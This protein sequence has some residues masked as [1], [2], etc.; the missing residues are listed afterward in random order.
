MLKK[1]IQKLLAKVLIAVFAF[2]L[3]TCPPF[4]K[5]AYV[6]A[7]GTTYYVSSSE[8]NDSNSGTS[9]TSP[10]RTLSKVSSI[11]FQSGDTIRLKGGD[12]WDNEF[13][14][15]HGSGTSGSPITLSSY[16]TG[17]PVIRYAGNVINLKNE[18]FWTI[19]G[20]EVMVLCDSSLIGQGNSN[21][22]IY[23]YY[24]QKRGKCTY[25]DI[26]IDDNVVY[27]EGIDRRT[28]GILVF[29]A[30]ERENVQWEMVRNIT[31]SNNTLYN[32]GSGGI[33]TGT[34][35]TEEGK[36]M[37][38]SAIF[39]NVRIIRN[40]IHDIG[41]SV[42]VLENANHSSM[43]WN[44]VYRGGAYTGSDSWGPG[45]IWPIL[46]SHIEM[47]FNEAYGMNDSNSGWDGTGLNI[48]WSNEYVT[49]QYNY[50]HDNEGCGITSMANLGSRILNN[51][52]KGN[53]GT[54][55]GRAQISLCDFTISDEL[56]RHSGIKNM[57]VADNMIIVDQPDACA[58]YTW[59]DVREFPWTGNSYH[60][61]RIV[62]K[63]GVPGTYS[64]NIMPYTEVDTINSNTIYGATSSTF[65]AVKYNVDRNLNEWKALGYDLDSE[66]VSTTDTGAPGNVSN[67]SAS[68]SQTEF[69]MNLSWAAATDSGS[70]IDHYNIYRWTDNN[71]SPAYKYMVGESKTTSFVDKEELEP[72]TT[73]YYKVEAEDK[74][75][76]V[77]LVSQTATATSGTAPA[78]P[79]RVYQ[80][81]ENF[82]MLQQ[83]YVWSYQY[84]D[85]SSYADLP[86]R[87]TLWNCWRYQDTSL[88]V[89]GYWLAPGLDKDAVMKWTAP[90]DGNITVSSSGTIS[91]GAGGDG[92]N[93]KVL[94]G[95]T[96]VWPSSGWQLVTNTSPVNFPSAQLSVTKGEALYFIVN[97][98]RTNI[99][100]TTSWD[101]VITYT[102]IIYPTPSA[103]PAVEPKL[104]SP[105]TI[106][107]VRDDFED[108]NANGWT[109]LGGSWSVVTDPA[110]GSKV[111]E[112]S[113]TQGWGNAY[114]G[115]SSW[116]D[117]TV[118]AKFKPIA[119][120]DSYSSVGVNVMHAD[121]SNRYT[122]EFRSNMILITKFSGGN[123]I[124][125]SDKDYTI[126]PGNTYS[127]KVE[128]STNSWS[129]GQDIGVY[130]NGIKELTAS[131]ST[132]V[133]SSGRV[134]LDTWYTRAQFDDVVI[135]TAA[136]T[137]VEPQDMVV[138]DD[139]E[140]GNITGWTVVSGNWSIGFDKSRKLSQTGN[141]TAVITAGE[142]T[143]DNY[144]VQSNIKILSAESGDAVAKLDLRYMDNNNKYSAYIS[145]TGGIGIKKV[146]S[147]VETQLANKPYTI[148][149]GTEYTVKAIVSGSTI[150]LYINGKRELMVSDTAL[151][152]GKAALETFN[153]N[154]M[155]DEAIVQ[156]L[157]PG[158]QILFS[159][160]FE[161]GNVSDWNLVGGAWSVVDDVT[162]AYK[163]SSIDGTAA[164]PN[165]WSS[166]WNDYIVKA[167]IKFKPN[168]TGYGFAHIDFRYN[169]TNGNRYFVYISDSGFID[170]FKDVNGVRTW[171]DGKAYYCRPDREYRLKVVVNGSNYDVYIN[172]KK[173]L[174]VTD[175]DPYLAHGR[176]AL[177]TWHT[178]AYY[179]DVVV[180]GI[181]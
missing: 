103:A 105:L 21:C 96:Q 19:K 66:L 181:Y 52:V 137:W 31:I 97:K 98:N 158:T 154:V 108:G 148:N 69:A 126:T 94:K 43:K 46:S 71:F 157:A 170:I 95:S 124:L 110:T 134:A 89:G 36:R 147:G 165:N 8:G 77:G 17:R 155:Y 61:N 152:T 84:W 23:V 173:E 169:P 24:D 120:Y 163:Q 118:E 18:S 42:I 62:L 45:G 20:L 153:A 111:Y 60:D 4:S 33:S 58:I 39:Y 13:L 176:M 51:K 113:N 156:R 55:I 67:L 106:E 73:Y 41:N 74:N 81:S 11:T 162:K 78:K 122:V 149:L 127:L 53:V 125:L 92:I 139:F 175:S 128:V 56:P 44:V 142:S 104:K 114:I 32:L 76:N 168:T 166:S 164:Y 83:G 54:N 85:G 167:K 64:Y 146:V 26:I 172:G 70:G 138:Y 37:N 117:Y 86:D 38:S 174:S 79:I 102:S 101:P 99:Y 151:T 65:K 82:G 50:A 10:W 171:I 16:G 12:L 178:E 112:Q 180:Q 34:W 15:L 3:I 75:G 27:G 130:I 5:P 159:D 59:G 145:N 28:H 109:T 29:A 40:T 135:N 22:G 129:G 7:A 116:K 100:D 47:K 68:T 63:A 2:S 107:Q 143:L 119:F 144:I 72:N 25:S 90:Y 160:N 132:N 141:S 57:E 87:Y 179:D 115:D 161:D 177:E 131:D 14:N 9:E 91:V 48:D 6:Y 80:A 30:S 121:G 150:D 123:Q 49:M 88:C 133:R 35:M 140:N 93:A 136:N 1:P